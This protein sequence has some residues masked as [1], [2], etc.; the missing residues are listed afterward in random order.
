MMAMMTIGRAA[1]A[2][3]ARAWSDAGTATP[4]LD[5]VRLMRPESMV[6]PDG[7]KPVA[8]AMPG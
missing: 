7:I 2:P 1:S 6:S 8:L 5:E 4:P 3:I